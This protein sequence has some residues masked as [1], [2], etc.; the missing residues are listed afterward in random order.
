MGKSTSPPIENTETG[1][2]DTVVYRPGST[3]SSAPAV[4]N[5]KAATNLT[6]TYQPS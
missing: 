3:T 2:G 6:I 5:I 1:G 4:A